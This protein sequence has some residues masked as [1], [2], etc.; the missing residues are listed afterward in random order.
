MSYFFRYI[1]KMIRKKKWWKCKKKDTEN[2]QYWRDSKEY[3]NSVELKEKNYKD[4]MEE[5]EDMETVY[6][7]SGILLE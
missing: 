3:K 7:N 4:K 5:K 6:R 2:C 1:R